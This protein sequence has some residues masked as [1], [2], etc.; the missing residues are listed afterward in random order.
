MTGDQAL[1]GIGVLVTRPA[2]QAA[3][4][5]AGLAARGAVSVALPTIAIEPT[6]LQPPLVEALRA[7]ATADWWVFVSRNA[8]AH[9][10]ARLRELGIGRAPATRIMVVGHGTAAALAEHGLTVDLVPDAGFNSEALLTAPELADMTGRRVSI[11][12]GVG[13]R[14]LL[15]STLRARGAQVDYVEVYRRV[16]PALDA[17]AA[18][19]RWQAAGA[20]AVV[21]TSAEGLDNLLSMAGEHGAA[22]L[23]Q[24]L[25]VT[26]SDRIAE[27]AAG[28]GFTRC[29]VAPAPGDAEIIQTLIRSLGR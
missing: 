11:I 10:L 27:A 19:N 22:A 21:V 2:A 25:L 14:E 15:A 28:Y 12:R 26:V 4:L 20:G 3:A 29:E 17:D 8:V 13:G 7:A 9:G 23:R 16:Q 5:C 6:P 18:M 24:A 1:A